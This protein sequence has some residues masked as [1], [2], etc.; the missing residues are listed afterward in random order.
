MVAVPKVR[1]SH[2]VLPHNVQNLIVHTS[3]EVDMCMVSLHVVALA[4]CGGL[5]CM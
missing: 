3:H 4:A 1:K 5:D 2:T